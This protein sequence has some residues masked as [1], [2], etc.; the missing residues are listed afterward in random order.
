M[1]CYYSNLIEGH[2]T[3]P[4][5]IERALKRDYSDDPK[6]RNLQQEASAHIA[7]QSWIDQGGVKGQALTVG[8]IQ[9]IH[10]RFCENLSEKMLFVEDPVT[11]ENIPSFLENGGQRC[12]SGASYRHK[13]GRDYALFETPRASLCPTRMHRF[14]HGLSHGASPL[15]VDS[16]LY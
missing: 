16:S 8:A 10:R 6:K 13:S 12:G 14:D 7:V 15:I 1:N 3:H 11:G 9:E 4:I 2:D 5:E